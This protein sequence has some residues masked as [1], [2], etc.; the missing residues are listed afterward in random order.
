MLDLLLKTTLDYRQQRFAL[1][2]RQSSEALFRLISDI[3]DLSRI[4]A[5][6]IE[7]QQM[8][9][10]PAALMQE[11]ARVVNTKASEKGLALNVVIA[12]QTPAF[13]RGDEGRLRQV[14]LNLLDNAI[15]FT[16]HG[17][18]VLRCEL[19]PEAAQAGQIG[20]RF[21]IADTGIGIAPAAHA[22]LFGPFTQLD[23]SISRRFG[24]IGLGLCIAKRLVERMGG[25]IRVDSEE[26]K[27]STFWFQVPLGRIDHHTGL[28]PGMMEEEGHN[29]GRASF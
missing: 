14:I 3:L 8:P 9:F 5:G 2:A 11:L 4:E 25:A 19:A 1:T 18:I 21:S 15:K 23:G 16:E 29:P 28:P 22:Q 12:P 27:G 17:E 13:A 6:Q 10:S 7:L 20:L 24:G 26:S